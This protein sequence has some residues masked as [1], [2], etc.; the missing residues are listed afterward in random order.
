MGY[1]YDCA[2]SVLLCAEDNAS[3]LGFDD[4]DEIEACLEVERSG[5]LVERCH[6]FGEMLLEMPLISDECLELLL[7][8]ELDHL[9][10]AD[11]AER[12]LSGALDLSIR[13]DAIDWISKV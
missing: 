5:V 12:L 4:G 7:K 10:R 9:P 3:I 2:A 8:K 6:L 1:S 13:T 11:Y